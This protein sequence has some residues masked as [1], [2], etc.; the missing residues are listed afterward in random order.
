MLQGIQ[1]GRKKEQEVE[2]EVEVEREREKERERR[3]IDNQEERSFLTVN[4]QVTED[5]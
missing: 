4:Q 2:V 1:K 3:F 5:R